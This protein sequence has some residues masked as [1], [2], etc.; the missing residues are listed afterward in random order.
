[1]IF[2]YN[3]LVFSLLIISSVTSQN[4][5]PP[6]PCYANSNTGAGGVIGNSSYLGGYNEEDNIMFSFNLGTE[7]GIELNDVLVLYIDTGIA[8]RSII[9]ST[10]DD[11]TDAY[12]IAITNSNEYGFGST[13]TFPA[14]FQASY[15]IAMDANSTRLYS[16]PSEGN[17]GSGGLNFITVVNSTLT[18]SSQSGFQMI[19]DPSDLGISIGDYFA[20]LGVY[21]GHNG[22]NYDEGYG[23]GITPGTQGSDNIT[24]EGYMGNSSCWLDTTLNTSELS[25]N[26]FK[27]HYFNQELYL[28]GV[29]GATNIYVYNMNGRK[30]F[31]ISHQVSGSLSIPL[32][33][34]KNKLHFVVIENS[35]E[36][37]VLKVVPH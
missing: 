17:I 6:P 1:M 30:I 3:I 29:K 21:V 22:Y 8:G 16:I 13:I 31:N 9:D 37:K 26:I 18:S 32:P 36:Q 34:N 33:L 15:A 23:G 27:A 2:K 28:E 19:I 10:V 25:E 11:N 7:P 35:S 24:F 14:N 4:R 20:M 5:I 12:T